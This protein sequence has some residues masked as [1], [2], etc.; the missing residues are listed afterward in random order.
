[1]QTQQTK[2]RWIQTLAAFTAGST[3]WLIASPTL[4]AGTESLR[5]PKPL[6]HTRTL[7]TGEMARIFGARPPGETQEQTG[8]NDFSGGT[9]PWEGSTGSGVSTASGNKLTQHPVVGWVQRGGLPIAFTLSH[10]SV[11]TTSNTVGKKWTHSFNVY[12][13]FGASGGGGRDGRGN[14]GAVVVAG[15]VSRVGAVDM[16]PRALAAVMVTQV[17]CAG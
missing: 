4:A 14:V 2:R 3:G 15:V 7:T 13:K 9:E 5:A 11:G 8:A 17:Q 1:M 16:V 10:S 6:G 12:L